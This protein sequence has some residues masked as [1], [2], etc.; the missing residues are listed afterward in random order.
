MCF[1]LKFKYYCYLVRERE[2]RP[3]KSIHLNIFQNEEIT[4]QWSQFATD[5]FNVEFNE[6]AFIIGK[7]KIVF[8]F[9][10]S[11]TFRIYRLWLEIIMVGQWK[12][13]TTRF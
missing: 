12:H 6:Y 4:I 5:S 7:E 10:F 13:D 9:N 8:E 1:F 2:K 11:D 3:K